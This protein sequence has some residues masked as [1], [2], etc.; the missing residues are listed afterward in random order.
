MPRN[1]G[2]TYSLPAGN[3]VVTGTTISSVWANTTLSD[4]ATAMTDSLSRSGDGAMLAPL[5]LTAGAVGTPGLTWSL[6]T[7]SGLYRAGAGD[8]RYS[9]SAADALQ[10][11]AGATRFPAGVVGTPGISFLV[12]TD[13]GIY[14]VAADTLAVSAGGTNRF[15]VGT[16]GA[17]VRSGSLY[18]TDGDATNPA[19]RFD[20][21]TN[22]GIYRAGP[23]SVGVS[24]GG[25]ASLF[26]ESVGAFFRD[27]TAA[28]PGLTFISDPNTGV[29][30]SGADQIAFSL[31]GVR[32][33]ILFANGL[34]LDDGQIFAPDG[35]VTLPSLSFSSDANTGFYHTTADQIAIALGGVTAGQIVQG[36]FTGTLTGMSGATS[37]TVNYQRVGNLV[38]MWAAAAITGTSNATTFTMTGVPA[39]IRPSSANMSGNAANFTSNALSNVAGGFNLS[40]GGTMTFGIQTGAGYDPNGWPSISTKGLSAGWHAQYSIG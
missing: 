25:T 1:S 14:R 31:A 15:E 30:R 32:K 35:A 20:A 9:V 13:L 21:D 23:D 19:I 22:S 16:F 8:F 7:T 38:H 34:Q 39:I 6:E 11:L 3:P 40:S 36:S 24:A 17:A 29:Y 33:A 10:I 4:L 12:D 18:M 2:G 27:G 37:G 5:E 28:N 26:V